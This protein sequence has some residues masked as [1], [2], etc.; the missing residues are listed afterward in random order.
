MMQP[1]AVSSLQQAKHRCALLHATRN[2]RADAVAML[3][4][5]ANIHI[6]ARAKDGA[7]CS[8]AWRHAVRCA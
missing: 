8:V 2:N 5:L 1:G 4:A 7:S 6:D 3:L